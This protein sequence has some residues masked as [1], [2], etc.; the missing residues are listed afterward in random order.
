MEL[1]VVKRIHEKPNPFFDEFRSEKGDPIGLCPKR[2]WRM[3]GIKI[4]ALLLLN[5]GQR[6]GWISA[7]LGLT[8]ISLSP[9]IHEINRSGL[10]MLRPQ[11]RSG[12]PARLT[13]GMQKDLVSHLEK[14]PMEFGLNRAHWDGLT[15][16]MHLKRQFGL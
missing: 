2:P 14:S 11:I 6:P 7:V 12:H 5:E 9:W 8:R 16:A 3:V 4:P 13:S 15:V 1:N 10:S